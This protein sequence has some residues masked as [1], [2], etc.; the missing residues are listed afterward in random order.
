MWTA[1]LQ[2]K[3]SLQ[4]LHKQAEMEHQNLL[5]VELHTDFFLYCFATTS[6]T[7]Q[8]AFPYNELMCL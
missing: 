4:L 1:Y 3:G 5:K 2:I 7:S 8:T 6:K